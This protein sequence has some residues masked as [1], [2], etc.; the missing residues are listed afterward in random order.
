MRNS[1]L[2]LSFICLSLLSC[3]NSRI[4]EHKDWEEHFEAYNIKKAGF[5][6]RDQTHDVVH[7]YNLDRD[8]SHFMPASTF[9]IFCSLVALELGIATDDRFV[10]KWDST[11]S[12]IPDRCRKDMTLREAFNESCIPYFQ[13]LAR[14]IGREN[15]QHYL[16]T[17]KYG[18][19]KIGGPID[20]FWLNNTLQISPDEQ[21]GLVK[22]LY[23][24][25]LPFSER[26]QRIVRSIMLQEEKDGMKLY[27]RT[28]WGMMP[29]KEV[30]WVVGFAEREEHVKEPEKSM[31]KSDVRNYP[32]FFAENFEIAAGDSTQDWKKVRVDI[33]KGLLEHFK[34]AETKQ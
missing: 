15:M 31:N 27:Y 1:L 8:T 18:N 34:K 26:S 3:R 22:R 12:N 17:V 6:L 7:Y 10:I 13:E 24:N 11:L 25:Q 30:L 33:L 4:K 16:D 32:Y 5:I 9:N 21:L 2:L 23:F 19:R 28:G 20:S 29:D 14:R